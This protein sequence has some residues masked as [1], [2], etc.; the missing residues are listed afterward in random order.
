MPTTN[1]LATAGKKNP[2]KFPG[3][4]IEKYEAYPKKA[5]KVNDIQHTMYVYQDCFSN[6]EE[7]FYLLKGDDIVGAVRLGA[8]FEINMNEASLFTEAKFEKN[9]YGYIIKEKE[10]YD[11]P[12]KIAVEKD[13][14]VINVEKYLPENLIEIDVVKSVEE[15]VVAA[16]VLVPSTPDLHGDIYDEVNV[17][18]AAYYFMEHYLE[19]NNGI[20]I[21]H[22]NIVERNA[23]KLLQTFI[24]EEPKNFDV[25]LEIADNY[26]LKEDDKIKYPKGTW[27][28]YARIISDNLWEKVKDGKLTGWSIAGLVNVK[29]LKK[30]L[31]YNNNEESDGKEERS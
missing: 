15:R 13:E 30:I 3:S 1:D 4:F 7:S 10:L 18:A 26:S 14:L 29:E 2:A 9:F 21:M 23:I 8:G 16:A 6:K 20:D 17:R 19:N 28:M 31:K 25:E 12:K 27:I 24:I 5:L 11:E 22:N